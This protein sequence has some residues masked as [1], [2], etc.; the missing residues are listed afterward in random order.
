V[1]ICCISSSWCRATTAKILLEVGVEDS[2]I[3]DNLHCTTPPLFRIKI[4]R[5]LRITTAKNL[6]EVG[7][8]DIIILDNLL[9]F[10]SSIIKNVVHGLKKI[11]GCGIVCTS[12][13][14]GGGGVSQ[15]VSFGI[16]R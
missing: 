14:R 4:S 11:V 10:F 6:L 1:R 5:F 13:Q 12:G 8:E 9:F 3:L 15:P 7:I 16:G 2:H